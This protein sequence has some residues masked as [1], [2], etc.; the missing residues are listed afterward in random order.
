MKKSL[1]TSATMNHWYSDEWCT[2]KHA[3]TQE[4]LQEIAGK[5]RANCKIEERDG[6]EG[7]VFGTYVCTIYINENLGLRYWV[8]D[9]FG[10]ITEI[11]EARYN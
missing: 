11:D 1:G 3:R 8:K 6:H 4:Q 2:D 7:D 9:E 5:I 10:H